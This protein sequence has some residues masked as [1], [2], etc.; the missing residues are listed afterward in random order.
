MRAM[1]KHP[2]LLLL[3]EPLVALDD[4]E[5]AMLIALINA[6]AAARTSAIVY[7]SHRAETALTADAVFELIP[8]TT[9]SVGRVA[10]VN[11][12]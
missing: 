12:F 1:V 4:E 6:V 11:R 3:D 8:Q 2:P 10:A 9:G 5:S 7:I